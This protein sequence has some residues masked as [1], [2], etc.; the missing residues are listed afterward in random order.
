MPKISP[1]FPPPIFHPNFALVKVSTFAVTAGTMNTPLI[2][3][4]ATLI[5]GW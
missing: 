3:S 1:S 4:H 5:A 2:P